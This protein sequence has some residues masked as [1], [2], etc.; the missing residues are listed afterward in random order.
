MSTYVFAS[1][2]CLP[3]QQAAV[4]AALERLA[5]A[6]RQEPGCRQYRL[7]AA[8]EGAP[9]LHVFEEYADTAALAAHRAAPHYRAYRAFVADK[10]AAPVEVQRMAAL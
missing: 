9:G 1:L 3:G 6:S 5:A 2:R 4:Q 10:L 8:A 7:F